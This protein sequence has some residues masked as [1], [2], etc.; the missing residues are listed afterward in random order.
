MGAG[1]SV[2]ECIKTTLVFINALIEFL[3]S[4]SGIHIQQPEARVI[5]FVC[6][7]ML[8]NKPEKA[9][10]GTSTAPLGALSEP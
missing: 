8:W 1:A 4:Q 7:L 5:P 2:T 6:W 10:V 9:W 3:S